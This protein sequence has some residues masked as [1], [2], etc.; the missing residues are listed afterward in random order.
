MANSR[1][2]LESLLAEQE[3]PRATWEDKTE[4]RRV[5]TCP[6]CQL[7]IREKDGMP[8]HGKLS[9]AGEQLH[10]HGFCGKRFLWPEPT[11]AERRQLA[12]F[13]KRWSNS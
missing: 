12:H 8:D 6:H 9:P 11:D 3:F 10:V 2:L 1:Q 13:A 5:L 4:I 7:E